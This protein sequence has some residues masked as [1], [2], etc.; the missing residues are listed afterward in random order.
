M[1]TSNS[2]IVGVSPSN[3]VVGCF[4]YEIPLLGF[5]SSPFHSMLEKKIKKGQK[6]IDALLFLPISINHPV[7]IV[8]NMTAVFSVNSRSVTIRDLEKVM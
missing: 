6:V 1:N 2:N 3:H 4:C 7:I 8:P 5:N